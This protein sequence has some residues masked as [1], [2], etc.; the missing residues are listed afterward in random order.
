MQAPPAIR[1][2]I[3][4]DGLAGDLL[5]QRLR[6]DSGFELVGRTSPRGALDAGQRAQPDFVVLPLAEQA[7]AC[8]PDGLLDTVERVKVVSL[9]AGRGRSYLT[10]LVGDVS[11]DELAETLRRAAAREALR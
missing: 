2:L 6:E 5:E 3:A 11:P 10:E 9:E 7:A 4:L 1:V 8:E